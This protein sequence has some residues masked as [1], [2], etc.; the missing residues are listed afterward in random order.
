MTNEPVRIVAALNAALSA[1]LAILLFAGVSPDL[2]A[3]LTLAVTL[4]VVFIGETVRSRVT[5]VQ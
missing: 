4:W 3:A 1:T 5:P 2:V